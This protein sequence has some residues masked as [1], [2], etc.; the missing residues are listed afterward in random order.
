MPLSRYRVKSIKE[1]RFDCANA[2]KMLGWTPTV[3]VRNGLDVSKG[4]AVI[5][6]QLA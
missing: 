1:L 5:R 3:G 2:E 4:Q 6:E